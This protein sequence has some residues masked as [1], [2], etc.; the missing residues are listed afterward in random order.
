MKKILCI[1]ALV[2]SLQSAFAEMCSLQVTEIIYAGGPRKSAIVV[3]EDILQGER[4]IRKT[5]EGAI[6]IMAPDSNLSIPA[7]IAQDSATT[8]VHF[9]ASLDGEMLVRGTITSCK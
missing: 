6:S 4:W 3:A 8:D 2:V 7:V 1:A 5:Q 9:V